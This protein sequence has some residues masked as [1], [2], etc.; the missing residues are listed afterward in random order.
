MSFT[1]TRLLLR[2]SSNSIKNHCRKLSKGF[3]GIFTRYS[4]ASYHRHFSTEKEATQDLKNE[5]EFF[6]D[7][8]EP[9][10]Q[11][12][13]IDEITGGDPELVKTLN[14]CQMEINM[15]AQNGAQVPTNM[16]SEYWREMVKLPGKMQ[17]TNYLRFLW[18]REQKRK[19]EKRKKLENHQKY[20]ESMI[21][22]GA[23][24]RTEMS[25]NSPVKY[26]L[27]FTSLVYR[28][29][30]AEM[31]RLY[32]FKLLQAMLFGPHILVDCGYEPYMNPKE[33][34]LCA[35]QLLFMW[36]ENRDCNNPFDVIFCNLK[37]SSPL[38]SKLRKTLAGIDTDPT[39]PFNYTEKNYLDLYPKEN[40]VYLTPHCTETLDKF[41]GNDIYIIGE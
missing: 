34:S 36:S 21:A 14:L 35:K 1:C 38:L 12:A 17:R 2:Y 30:E 40:L 26:G 24:D 5:F 25:T 10:Y 7:A 29:R 33:I 39:F 41:N 13:N 23:I 9:N 18:L 6:E 8:I 16:T 28:I 32:N 4:L 19:N 22:R 37:N 3:P 27:N 20:V 15:L 31:N 11:D